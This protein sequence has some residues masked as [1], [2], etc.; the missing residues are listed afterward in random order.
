[1]ITLSDVRCDYTPLPLITFCHILA[2]SILSAELF[3]L[4]NAILYIQDSSLQNTIIFSDSSALSSIENFRSK[5]SYLISHEIIKL[6]FFFSSPLTL[7][8][9]PSYTQ[10]KDNELADDTAKKAYQHFPIADIPFPLT[11][12]KLLVKHLMKVEFQNYW[13]FILNSNKLKI[14]IKSWYLRT[15]TLDVAKQF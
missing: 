1:M 7:Y 13:N 5:Q 8:W 3:A 11:D 2:F 4:K 6:L 14:T 9:V 12:L 15:T 10:I